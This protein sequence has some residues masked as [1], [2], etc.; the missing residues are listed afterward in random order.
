MPRACQVVSAVPANATIQFNLASVCLPA[1][2]VGFRKGL[3]SCVTK[4][5]LGATP[6]GA[7]A[8]PSRASVAKFAASAC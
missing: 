3:C 5:T 8:H 4:M 1:G 2:E 6:Q 7:I